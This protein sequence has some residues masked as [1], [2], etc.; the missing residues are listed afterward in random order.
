MSS[1]R[2]NELEYEPTVADFSDIENVSLDCLIIDD[3]RV[4][5]RVMQ[6]TLK[7]LGHHAI[8]ATSGEEGLKLLRDGKFTLAFIDLHMPQMSGYELFEQIKE[9]NPEIAE[10]VK[11][12]AFTADISKHAKANIEESGFWAT[13]QKPFKREDVERILRKIQFGIVRA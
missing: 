4:N 13:L 8:F 3:N 11:M 10:N 1:I 5:C 9:E 12:I 7:H 6:N 2:D